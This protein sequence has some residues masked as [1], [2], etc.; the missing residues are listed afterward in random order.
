MCNVKSGRIP[1]SL[2][3][4]LR[5]FRLCVCRRAHQ[6]TW[7][8]QPGRTAMLLQVPD[9]QASA[10]PLLHRP[11]RRLYVVAGSITSVHRTEGVRRNTYPLPGSCPT[12][13][14]HAGSPYNKAS[15]LVR[16]P[17]FPMSSNTTNSVYDRSL[18]SSRYSSIGSGREVGQM[19]GRLVLVSV[20]L[21]H[22]IKDGFGIGRD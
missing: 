9:V 7:D 22:E 16:E 13:N 14:N 8:P 21:W 12:A 17:Y 2:A 6:V 11:R 19:A 18:D 1:Y 3:A 15:Y 5:V 4:A 10:V 20:R